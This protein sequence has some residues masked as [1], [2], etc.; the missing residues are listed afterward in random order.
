MIVVTTKRGTVG[1]SY[2]NVQVSYGLSEAPDNRLKMMNTKEKIAFERGIYE[3]FPGLNVG[4]RVYQLLKK[5]DNGLLTKVEAETEI[6]R[7]S[8]I[9]TNWFDKIFRVAHTQ[10]YSISLSGGNETTQYYGS[11]S[12]LV[13]G[14]GDAQ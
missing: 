14:G 12:Y 11:L 2:I 8:K 4:G 10:N 3:D 6:E 13:A 5:V 9:N 7:L 1:R